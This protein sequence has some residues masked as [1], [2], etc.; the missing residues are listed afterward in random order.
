M[1][2]GGARQL[3]DAFAVSKRRR[4]FE[5]H[6]VGHSAGSILH[7]ALAKYIGTSLSRSGP[8]KGKGLGLEIKSCSLWAP[9]ATVDLYEDTFLGLL[10]RGRLKEL[11]LFTLP[12]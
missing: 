12:G 5:I 2:A 10:R 4:D 8:V 9:A 6:L 7:A 3:I 11:N 1:N